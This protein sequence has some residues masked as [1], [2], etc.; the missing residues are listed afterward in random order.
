MQLAI[1]NGS[2][3]GK[4]SNTGILMEQFLEGLYAFCDKQKIAAASTEENF[5]SVKLLSL[6]GKSIRIKTPVQAADDKSLATSMIYLQRVPELEQQLQILEKADAVILAF[7]LYTDAMPGIVKNFIEMAHEKLGPEKLRGK[8]LGF[9]IQSGFPEALHS[10]LV[11]RYMNKL[12][13][14]WQCQTVGS[15]IRG[16]VEGIQQRPFRFNLKLFETFYE[17]GIYFCEHRVFSKE[18]REKLR[19]PFRF[20]K[21]KL[22]VVRF[23]CALGIFDLYWK[24]QLRKNRALK[25]ARAKPWGR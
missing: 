21:C 23:L 14:R 16:G 11:E 19:Q 12:C 8:K 10:E 7:P 20:E 3:R 18:I 15:I 22:L 24:W 5:E 25:K 1:F 2:P 13:E 17:L 6:E 4:K 9:I